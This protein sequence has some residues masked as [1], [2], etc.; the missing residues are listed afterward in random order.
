MEE[1]VPGDVDEDA[2]FEHVGDEGIA[3]FEADNT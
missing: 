1:L 2:V 3:F